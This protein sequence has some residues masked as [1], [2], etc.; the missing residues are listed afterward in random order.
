MHGE[1]PKLPSYIRETTV[2][3]PRRRSPSRGLRFVLAVILSFVGFQYLRLYSAVL[4]S[5]ESVQVPLRAPEWLDKCQLLDAQPGPPPD[6]NTR[7]HSDRFVPGTRATLIT[8]CGP[9]F[10]LY[11][12]LN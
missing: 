6:F 11:A 12:E 7:T 8:V 3:Q 2:T 1:E 5:S 9:T 10:R 4:K